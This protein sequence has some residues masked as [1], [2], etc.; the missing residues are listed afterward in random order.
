MIESWRIDYNQVHPHRALGHLKPE[1]FTKAMQM[2]ETN[3][4]LHNCIAATAAAD[5]SAAKP[6]PER[7]HLSVLSQEGNSSFVYTL[8]T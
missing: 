3:A 6:K 5:K 1:E 7:S 8:E 4:G 2:W